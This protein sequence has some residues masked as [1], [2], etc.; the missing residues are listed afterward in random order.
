LELHLINFERSISILFIN[1]SHNS[2]HNIY[3]QIAK[4][5]DKI[6]LPNWTSCSHTLYPKSNDSIP[7]KDTIFHHLTYVVR[8]FSTTFWVFEGPPCHINKELKNFIFRWWW[9]IT[10]TLN[11]KPLTPPNRLL[12][13]GF[14][15]LIFAI[16]IINQVLLFT[17][18][19]NFTFRVF[20]LVMKHILFYR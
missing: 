12:F 6:S 5:W 3:Q 2:T 7:P 4:E 8:W 19:W 13:L 16:Q 18:F 1:L 11:P 10:Y 14:F 17:Y 9:I 20:F 15:N